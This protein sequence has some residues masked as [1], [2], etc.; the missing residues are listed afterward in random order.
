M[1]Q[2][3]QRHHPFLFP[4]FHHGVLRGDHC[5][6]LLPRQR[7]WPAGI[8]E[9]HESQSG[10][11]QCRALRM[12]IGKKKNSTAASLAYV[13]SLDSR[14]PNPFPKKFLLFF[15]LQSFLSL[16][17]FFYHHLL[18]FHRRSSRRASYLLLLSP[19]LLHQYYHCFWYQSL[20]LY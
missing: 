4:D 16:I 8:K 10:G 14:E 15:S 17:V 11:Q 6:L 5:L 9:D 20:V 18:L 2:H 13:Y 12:T 7:V 1:F 3:D 19:V